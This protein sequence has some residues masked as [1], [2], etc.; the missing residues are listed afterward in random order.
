MRIR[1]CGAILLTLAGAAVHAATISI[2]PFNSTQIARVYADN[3]PDNPNPGQTNPVNVVRS[4]ANNSPLALG[5]QREFIARRVNGIGELKLDVNVSNTSALSLASA[6][7]VTGRGLIVWDGSDT[8]V[9]AFDPVTGATDAIKRGEPDAFGLTGS[10]ATGGVDLTDNGT[11][12]AILFHA[13]ADNAGL[14][15]IFHFYK[16]AGVFATA[17]LNLPGTTGAFQLKPYFIPFSSFAVTGAAVSSYDFFRDVKAITLQLDGRNGSD[18]ALDLFGAGT[19][20]PEPSTVSLTLA[21]GLLG[22]WGIRRR[23]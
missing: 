5:G 17:T 22:A 8:S 19:P 21:A 13:Y 9:G 23:R 20:V 7:S 1:F 3:D 18:A 15:L 4:T 6:S 10:G 14:P 11:N 12:S 16:S 2:D